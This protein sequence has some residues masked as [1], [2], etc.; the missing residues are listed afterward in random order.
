MVQVN[1]HI[2]LGQ[3]GERLPLGQPVWTEGHQGLAAH[4]QQVLQ[5]AHRVVAVVPEG[6]AGQGRP[7]PARVLVGRPRQGASIQRRGAPLLGPVQPAHRLEVPGAHPDRVGLRDIRAASRPVGD[8]R[9]GVVHHGRATGAGGGEVVGEA[10]G[11]A[12]LVGRE[13]AQAREGELD[14]IL[15]PAGARARSAEDA[16]E[17]HDVLPHAQGPEQDMPLHDLTRAR[18][19][20][21]V[22]VGPAAGLAVDPLDHVEARVEGMDALGQHLDPIRAG[23]PRGLEG[24]GPPARAV[25][26]RRA[27]R[28]GRRGVEVVDDRLDDAAVLP[29]LEAVPRRQVLLQGLPERARVVRVGD[30]E[31]P[32][33]RVERERLVA[34]LGQ[35]QQGVVLH[36]HHGL[37]RRRRAAHL[38]P[39]R[40][41][42]Q[43]EPRLQLE[44]VREGVALGRQHGRR[45]VVEAEAPLPAALEGGDGAVGVA[46]EEAGQLDQDPAVLLSGHGSRVQ[47]TP[48]E[49]LP[50]GRGLGRRPRGPEGEVRDL[51][52]D[53]PPDPPQLQHHRPA[54]L[55]PVQA[56]G[57]RAEARGEALHIQTLRKDLLGPR[58]REL[59]PDLGAR[60]VDRGGEEARLER[61]APLELPRRP[62]GRPQRA[63]EWPG[64]PSSRPEATQSGPE[65]VANPP[66]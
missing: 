57:V 6:R 46:R 44:V 41:A 2:H 16:L 15:G 19:H 64:G 5:R 43:D 3:L 38:A 53:L 24:L 23:Q 51:E 29:D 35:T 37:R 30:L 60:R 45:L 58:G 13:L 65:A 25:Q 34:R 11:V 39:G 17:E 56:H 7:E 21:R 9:R 1:G 33:A 20:D 50:H 32:P 63:S 42:A 22:A 27:D 28:L 36:E 52:V 48:G 59:D 26:Q 49:G 18:V 4:E 61:R 31:A 40:V 47:Q 12:D 54:G 10:Q 14:G 8:P 66:R 62:P 55:S